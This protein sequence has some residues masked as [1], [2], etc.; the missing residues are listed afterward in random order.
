M[1]KKI[2]LILVLSCIT[3][4]RNSENSDCLNS[5]S[6]NNIPPDAI[7]V[8][9]DGFFVIRFSNIIYHVDDKRIVVPVFKG[10]LGNIDYT[11]FELYCV[12]KKLLPAD[13]KEGAFIIRARQ[14]EVKK[15]LLELIKFYEG[16]IL[17]GYEKTYEMFPVGED[18]TDFEWLIIYKIKIDNIPCTIKF[19][20]IAHEKDPSYM[21]KYRNLKIQDIHPDERSDTT[22]GCEIYV[23]YWE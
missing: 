12:Q 3:G 9:N 20:V 16:N 18:N 6:L 15:T 19:T 21:E 7:E 4:C 17:K 22:I 13:T 11:V 8:V 2:I 23:N 1:I 10:N 5:Y 14:G